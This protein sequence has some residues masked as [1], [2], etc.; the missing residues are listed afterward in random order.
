MPRVLGPALRGLLRAR[1]GLRRLA[2][3]LVPPEIRLLEHSLA[4]IFSHS[5]GVVVR[6]GVADQLG[7][8][9]LPVAVLAQQ[10]AVDPDALTRVIRLLASEGVFMLRA[11]G[12]VAHTPLSRALRHDHRGRHGPVGCAAAADYMTQSGN[13]GAFTRLDLWLKTGEVPF[14][15]AHGQEIWSWLRAHPEQ[16]R[17]FVEMMG[18]FSASVVPLIA[19]FPSFAQVKTVIDLAGG[20]GVL[21]AE[22]LRRHPHVRGVLIDQETTLSAVEVRDPRLT[23]LVGDLF[24][25]LPTPGEGPRAWVLKNI[26]HDWDTATCVGILER[27]HAAMEAEDRL[28]VIESL[29]QEGDPL[30]VRADLQMA[31]VCRGR[32]RT[33]AEYRELLAKAGFGVERVMDGGVVALI[34]ARRA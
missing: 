29:L 32:E 21:L 18:G 31:A 4:P 33:E 20:R 27:V 16:G 10:C 5:L 30:V 1:R 13:L 2:D 14:E 6:A 23:L 17:L 34:E 26:L 12:E 9:P 11:D 28:L 15:A 22:V 19:G 3:Q 24:G 25:P 8:H 7:E